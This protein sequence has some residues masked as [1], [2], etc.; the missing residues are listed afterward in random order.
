MTMLAPKVAGTLGLLALAAAA[1]PVSA[2]TAPSAPAPAALMPDIQ[3]PMEEIRLSHDARAR[4]TVPVTIGS[5]GPFAFL[6][7][8]GAERTVLTRQTAQVLGLEPSG[9]AR[10]VSV[11]GLEDVDLVKVAEISLGTRRFAGLE[12]PLVDGADLEA[13]GIVGLD[14]LQDQRITID[15]AANR[16]MIGNAAP[17][18]PQAD[19]YDIVVTARR[20]SGQLIMT[21]ATVDGVRTDVMIDTG[22]DVSIGNRALQRALS[23]QGVVQQARLV[24]V[25]GQSIAADVGHARTMRIGGM[26]INNLTFAFADA[27]AFAHLRLNR[28]P[29]LLLG[30]RDLSAFQ[31][32]A[33]D[34]ARRKVMFDFT[35]APAPALAAR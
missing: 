35:P 31:K 24:A 1:L 32:V 4:L 28:R 14:G 22:S 13:E 18:V 27:P 19:S 3:P 9:R 15:F 7:D 6:V 2:Q 10:L 12:A 17:D 21:E 33:I 8:T 11:A 20:R 23:R 16:L 5:A 30:M 34:F 25:T 29:A 26:D